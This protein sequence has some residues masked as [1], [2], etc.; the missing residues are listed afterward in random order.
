MFNRLLLTTTLILSGLFAGYTL[1]GQVDEPATGQDTLYI[2]EE[3]VVFDTL[4]LYDSLPRPSLLTK[5]DLIES[6]KQHRGVGTLYYHRGK[7]HLNGPDSLYKLS[8]SDLQTLFSAAEY[9]EY[10]KAKRN[11]YGSIPL[12]IL[13]SGAA[14]CMGIGIYQFASS[15]WLMSKAGDL[16]LDSDNLGHDIWMSAMGGFF[17]VAGSALVATGCFT[18]A[19]IM[20][21]RNKVRIQNLVNGYNTPATSLRLSLGPTPGG[22]GI[23]LSF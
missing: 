11:I 9:K 10:R 20:T 21:I 3:E 16:M 4:Y 13:G 23:T 1:F 8:N 7:M 15:F 14:V 22:V 6:F 2:I 17:L 12:Y 18:P 19:I 5:D